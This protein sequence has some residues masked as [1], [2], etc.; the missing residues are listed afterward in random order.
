MCECARDVRAESVILSVQNVHVLTVNVV[1][2]EKKFD[3]VVG[4]LSGKLV[5]GINEFLQ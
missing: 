1:D 3:F 5:H 4:T 2:F